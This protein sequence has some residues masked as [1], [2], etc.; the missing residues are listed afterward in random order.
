MSRPLEAAF[1]QTDAD[2]LEECRDA[3]AYHA[4]M[5]AFERE[6]REALIAARTRPLTVDEIAAIA[7]WAQIDVRAQPRKRV[8]PAP[9]D[10][11]AF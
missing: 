7:W 10:H 9:R 5:L 2:L 4:D 11:D 1:A 6:A 8:P 3:A